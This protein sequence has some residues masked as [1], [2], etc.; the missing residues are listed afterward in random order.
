MQAKPKSGQAELFKTPLAKIINTKHPLC[1]LGAKINWSEFDK[2]FGPLYSEGKGRPAK[3]TRL[4]VGLH[5]LKHTYNLSDE[6]V[7]AQWLENPYWQHFCGNEYFE[8]G[9]PIDASSMTRWRKRV[10]VAGMEKLLEETVS[11]G[12]DIGAL[13]K[14]SINKLNVDTTVQE[15]AIS[16]PTDAKL[17]HRMREKLV[18][19]SKEHGVELRQSYKFKSKYS[20]FMRGRYSHA[21]QMRRSNKELK[22]L[23]TYLGRV[24]RDI[25]R[26]VAGS[27][28]LNGVFSEPLALAQRILSQRRQDKDKLYSIHAPE[29]E[30]ISKGKAHK[31]YEFG[32]KVSVAA[33]SKECFIVG[34]KAYH[35][36]PYDGHTL[37][38]SITQ[39]E[40]IS[41]FK[42][43]DI[44]VDRGY[45][46]HNY[47]GQAIVYIAGR[48]TKKLKAS[49]RKWIRRRSAIE[50][51]IG[52][53]KTNGRLGR[54]Y[55]HGREGDNINAILSGC[56]YN[57]RKLLTVLLFCL[58]SWR[59]RLLPAS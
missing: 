46:G 14:A 26:K 27:E 10:S 12:L 7:V 8:H 34:M 24:V 13:K 52:H 51:V 11:T 18:A 48:G 50:A 37:E 5:Y 57:M 36:N 53:A 25:D 2:A 15:K 17:Y 23:R 4:M 29:V 47:T 19:L 28:R 55:L 6:E 22:R 3:P 35:G 1:I 41:G 49:V 9:F 58:F 44:Y 54:N 38:E 39:T 40:R 42:A 45:R 21:R 32:C 16:F 30:C 43:N 59:Q 20:L 56:G 31:K 33:T